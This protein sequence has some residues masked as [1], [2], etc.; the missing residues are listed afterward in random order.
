MYFIPT[1][2]MLGATV[3]V[4]DWWLWNIIPVTIG[5]IIGAVVFVAMI[6]QFAYGKKI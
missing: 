5:N 6:Y 1:G 4:A 3:S 2:M